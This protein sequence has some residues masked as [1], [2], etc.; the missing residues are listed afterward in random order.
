MIYRCERGIWPK[1]EVI[2]TRPNYSGTLKQLDLAARQSVIKFT[3]TFQ[4]L[5]LTRNRWLWSPTQQPW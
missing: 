2:I 5:M 4:V 3:A 1:V